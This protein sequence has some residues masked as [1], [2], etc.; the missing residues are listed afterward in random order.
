[1]GFFLS[2]GVAGARLK[3]RM[4]SDSSPRQGLEVVQQV[5][6]PRLAESKTVRLRLS[7]AKRVTSRLKGSV[8]T[9]R[10]TRTEPS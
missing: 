2:V 1:M 4:P 10:S 5:V 8:G 3:N 7:S 6:L 9:R